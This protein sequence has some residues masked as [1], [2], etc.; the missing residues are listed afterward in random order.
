MK[1]KLIEQNIDI[2]LL[3]NA[4]GKLDIDKLRS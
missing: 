4:I 3:G 1:Y 2:V